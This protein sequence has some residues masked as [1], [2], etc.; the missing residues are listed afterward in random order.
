MTLTRTGS[1]LS[2]LALLPLAAVLGACAPVPVDQAERSCL[3]DVQAANQPPRTEVGIGVASD[4]DGGVRPYGSVSFEIS[5]DRLMGRDP[6]DV[7]A[8]CVMRRSG[9]P[10]TVSLYDQPRWQG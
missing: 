8:Q 1:R 6:S 9:Q 2:L 5:S 7:F 3:R 4:F 10:P